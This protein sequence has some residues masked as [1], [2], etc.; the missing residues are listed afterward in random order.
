MFKLSGFCCWVICVPSLVPVFTIQMA[1][2]CTIW[3][4]GQEKMMNLVKKEAF[5]PRD[6][7]AQKGR[8]WLHGA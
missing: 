6:V 4:E 7:T 8:A 3:V 5:E 1:T 2:K